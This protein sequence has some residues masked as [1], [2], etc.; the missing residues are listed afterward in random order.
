[1]SDTL[2]L[3]KY[4]K[5]F[6]RIYGELFT[7][8]DRSKNFGMIFSLMIL[9]AQNEK[10]GLTQDEIRICLET[11]DLVSKISQSTVSRVLAQLQKYHYCDYIGDNVRE[12]R[13]YYT[14][15]NFSDLAIERIHQNIAEGEHVISQ[16]NDLANAIPN[17]N[18][19][20]EEIQILSLK[21][22]E[23]INYFGF[24]TRFYRAFLEENKKSNR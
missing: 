2:K 24:L 14:K 18:Q 9:K 4:E 11:N 19:N 21:I 15:R 5:E 16:M 20:D 3:S 23:I 17:E 12:K 10:Q 13:K 6:I 7:I 8:R 1:M 22:N